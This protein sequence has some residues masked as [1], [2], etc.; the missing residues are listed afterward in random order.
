[1]TSN[2]FD[3]VYKVPRPGVVT[4]VYNLKGDQGSKPA[5]AKSSQDPMAGW[6][7]TCLLTPAK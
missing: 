1:V 2:K 3:T 5:W 4:Q 6:G 7:C